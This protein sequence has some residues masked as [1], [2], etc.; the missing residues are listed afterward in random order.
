MYSL[1]SVVRRQD[2]AIHAPDIVTIPTIVKNTSK[3]IKVQIHTSQFI[4]RNFNL[5]ILKFNLG[6]T[7][8]YGQF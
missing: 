5:Q 8:V 1:G 6:N 4:K 2:N 3:A 7:Y